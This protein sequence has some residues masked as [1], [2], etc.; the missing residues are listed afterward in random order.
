MVRILTEPK[1]ALVKQYSRMFELEDVSLE[2]TEEALRSISRQALKRN[3]G[4]RALRAVIEDIMLDLMY[5]LPD[6]KQ[7]GA[8]YQLTGAL[9]EEALEGTRPSLFNSLTVKQEKESA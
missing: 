8:N 9:V 7:E 6:H 3:V 1:N 2:F 5:D 4:A